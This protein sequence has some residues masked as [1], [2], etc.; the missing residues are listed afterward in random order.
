M[1]SFVDLRLVA[2]RMQPFDGGRIVWVD[3]LGIAFATED[4][5]PEMGH[6]VVFTDGCGKFEAGYSTAAGTL[7][8]AEHSWESFAEAKAWARWLARSMLL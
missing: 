7:R 8:F 4:D 3:P 2:D 6:A 5:E 1:N